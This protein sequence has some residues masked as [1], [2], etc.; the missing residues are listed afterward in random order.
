M[1]SNQVI[2][3]PSPKIVMKK[4]LSSLL[5]PVGSNDSLGK[6]ITPKDGIGHLIKKLGYRRM[7]HPKMVGIAIDPL[8]FMKESFKD[9]FLNSFNLNTNNQPIE[10]DND[11]DFID[12]D[13]ITNMVDRIPSIRFLE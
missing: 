5:F 8:S 12:G 7:I 3:T 1:S 13:V 2:P 9:K 10:E 11:I 6:S 4:M